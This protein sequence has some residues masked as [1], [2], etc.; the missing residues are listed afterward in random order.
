MPLFQTIEQAVCPAC[1][2]AIPHEAIRFVMV[3]AR[4]DRI[5]LPQRVVTIHCERCSRT[6]QVRQILR[7]GS[8][9]DTSSIELVTAPAQIA[10]VT[11]AL[12]TLRGTTQKEPA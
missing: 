10:K 1:E 9:H 12:D 6:Y 2:S 3:P 5:G 11:A 7:G 8:W 4:R